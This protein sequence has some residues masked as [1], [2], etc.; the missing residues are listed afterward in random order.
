MNV[1]V[2]H[3]LPQS[4]SRHKRCVAHLARVLLPVG[5][6]NLHVN[7]Q[8][9]RSLEI[10]L[11]NRTLDQFGSC[12]RSG[13]RRLFSAGFDLDARILV[14]VVN[15]IDVLLQD[16]LRLVFSTAFFA[17]VDAFLVAKQMTLEVVLTDEL[18]FTVRTLNVGFGMDRSLVRFHQTGTGQLQTTYVALGRFGL[19]NSTD[20]LFHTPAI[21]KRSRTMLTLRYYRRVHSG[22]FVL[23]S[24]AKL[25]LA[26]PMID[27]ASVKTE[28][29]SAV[30]TKNMVAV[31]N[32][33]DVRIVRFFFKRAIISA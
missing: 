33:L 32:F 23:G 15:P 3:V 18:L 26:G 12:W 4:D 10:L 29:R 1:L 9:L 2:G 5:I 27:E 22:Y 21:L 6:V 19:V 8:S 30:R 17:E 25:T 13:D 24:F 31:M 14:R 16:L 28:L 20:V 11:A 7:P